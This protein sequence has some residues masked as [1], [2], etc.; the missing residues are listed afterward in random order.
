MSIE[1]ASILVG[2]TISVT[3]G[4]AQSFSPD[5]TNVSRG[6]QISDSS[7]A[8]IRTRDLLVFKNT[9]GQL[10]SDGKWSK[11][12]RSCKVVCPDLLP[13]GVTQDFPFIEINLVKSPLHSA[14]KL[15]ALKEKAI[16][17]LNDTDFTGFWTSGSIK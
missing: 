14:A 7:E 16:Q 9:N 10:Q 2:P 6:V 17:V 8:D 5:G 15:V 4:T 1:N 11:D 13:D 3:G 12:K